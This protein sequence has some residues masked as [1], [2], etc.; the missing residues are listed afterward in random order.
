M[1]QLIPLG[2][3]FIFLGVIIIM[4]SALTN[5]DKEKTDVKFGVGGFIGFIPFGFANDKEIFV[6]FHWFGISDIYMDI[7]KPS[8]IKVFL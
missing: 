2:I 8:K 5:I 1:K 7:I 6:F 3:I 4:I